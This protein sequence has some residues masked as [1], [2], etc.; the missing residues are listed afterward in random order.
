MDVYNP[1]RL[2][3]VGFHGQADHSRFIRR[4]CPAPLGHSAHQSLRAANGQLPPGSG[5]E[6]SET[7]G[8]RARVKDGEKAGRVR[9]KGDH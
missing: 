2:T 7:R 9:V 8:V 3:T 1:M 6:R 5:A 4:G